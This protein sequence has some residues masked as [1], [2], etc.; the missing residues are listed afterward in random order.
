MEYEIESLINDLD[1]PRDVIQEDVAKGRLL[2]YQ[3][4]E[5]PLYYVD[6]ETFIDYLVTRVVELRSD[7]KRAF[8]HA[9]KRIIEAPNTDKRM[10]PAEKRAVLIALDREI[11]KCV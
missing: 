9:A 1:L 5:D 10:D 4:N 11:S 3:H 8:W 7:Q 2:L 6:E